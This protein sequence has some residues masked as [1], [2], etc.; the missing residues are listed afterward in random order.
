MDGEGY[1]HAGDTS[2]DV[3]PMNVQS[4]TISFVHWEFH[5]SLAKSSWKICRMVPLEPSSGGRS[6]EK[7]CCQP[8]WVVIELMVWFLTSC[9]TEG[10]CKSRRSIVF[11][12]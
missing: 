9:L 6:V 1:G 5:C 4:K 10:T 8:V 3:P 2:S 11:G 12:T 7:G